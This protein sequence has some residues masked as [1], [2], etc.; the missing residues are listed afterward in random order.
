MVK[1]SLRKGKM[2][3]ERITEKN[4]KTFLDIIVLAMI[5]GEHLY[6]Y[7][8]IAAIHKEFG[9]LLSPGSLYPLLHF[10]EDN[11]L[12]KS[13][14]NGGKIIYQATPKGKIKFANA[15]TA[16]KVASQ[17][18]LKFVKLHGEISPQ[19]MLES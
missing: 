10:L 2:L 7:K 18:M 6:G 17:K 16:Y 1:T 4:V 8:I 3:E 12:I 9:I 14:F 11:K 5:N 13:N 19:P 15:L